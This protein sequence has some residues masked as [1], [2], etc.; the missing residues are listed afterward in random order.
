MIASTD[1]YCESYAVVE[2]EKQRRFSVWPH[3]FSV[4]DSWGVHSVTQ[5]FLMCLGL[6][7]PLM[8]YMCWFTSM[9][10]VSKHV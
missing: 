2:K 5:S 8:V 9:K 3:Y 1:I 7:F 6:F 10:K 4:T